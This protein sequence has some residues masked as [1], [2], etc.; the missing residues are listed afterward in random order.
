MGAQW[1]DLLPPLPPFPPLHY[2]TV[3]NGTVD[4]YKEGGPPNGAPI[5]GRESLVPG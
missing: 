3:E 1:K 4:G 2:T 5:E